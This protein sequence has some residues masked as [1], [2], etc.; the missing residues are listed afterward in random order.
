MDSEKLEYFCVCVLLSL[1]NLPPHMINTHLKI[2]ICCYPF[3]KLKKADLCLGILRLEFFRL[4][5]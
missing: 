4:T 5:N 2:L 3:A 1:G